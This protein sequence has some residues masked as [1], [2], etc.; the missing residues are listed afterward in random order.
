VGIS[1]QQLSLIGRKFFSW[2]KDT[3]RINLFGFSIERFG[4]RAAIA[5]NCRPIQG[6]EILTDHQGDG[7]EA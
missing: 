3:D 7:P 6:R 5:A 4:C 1:F 2:H